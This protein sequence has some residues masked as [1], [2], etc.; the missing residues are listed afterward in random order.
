MMLVRNSL[1]TWRRR[2]HEFEPFA[3]LHSDINSLFDEIWRG[4]DLEP[5]PRRERASRTF[6]P[7]ADVSETEKAYEIRT[8][9]PGLE[10]KDIDV[11]LLD[12]SLTIK[13]EKKF[14]NEVTKA[15][16]HMSERTYG[17]FCRS[18]ML[19]QEADVKRIA[20]AFDKGVLTVTLPKTKEAQKQAK[21]ISIKKG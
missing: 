12:G 17:S 8:E 7:V 4:F 10:E 3:G 21:K 19:P 13:G 20:A 6:Q 1:A 15:A 9:L 11:T 18:F 14:E 5:L 2:G 16:V